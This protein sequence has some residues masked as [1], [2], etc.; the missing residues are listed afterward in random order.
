MADFK[1]GEYKIVRLLLK[2][3]QSS[4]IDFDVDS[5]FL[6]IALKGTKAH[7]LVSKR[8]SLAKTNL[9]SSVSGLN[10]SQTSINNSQSQQNLPTIDPDLRGSS[11]GETAAL[12]M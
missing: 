3:C 10:R 8:S 1:F 4:P 6:D 7:G 11:A 12:L 9:N 2:K 5:T